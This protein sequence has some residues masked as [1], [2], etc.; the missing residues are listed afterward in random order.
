MPTEEEAKRALDAVSE[1]LEKLPMVTGLGIGTDS[2]SEGAALL[3][4]L[5]AK[6]KDASTMAA[7]PKQVEISRADG[8]KV[9]V[10]VQVIRQ[11]ELK[12]E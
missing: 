5:D 11:D 6:Q 4:Y 8:S 9:A 2:Q 1:Q 12:F 10:P 3:V 7:I